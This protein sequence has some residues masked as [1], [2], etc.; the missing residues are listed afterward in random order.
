MA[1]GIGIPAYNEE[2][3]I[4]VVITHLKK[5]SDTIIVC[6]DGSND[7]TGEIAEKLGATVINHS[8]NMGYGGA[9]RSLFL[10]AKELKLD[11]L[12]TFDADGQHQI[13]DIQQVMKP[14]KDK[15]A[16]IVIGSRFLDKKSKEMP[17]YR[18]MGI[19]LIT[20][21]TNLSITE[22]LT[23]SQSGFRAY[24][25]EVLEKIVPTD[26]GMGVSTE[27]LIKASKLDFKIAEVPIEVLYTGD[28]ST[29]DP[30]SHGTS[31]IISTLK[32]MSIHNP[33]KFYGIPGL[34][35]LI[36]GLSF[37]A[38]T[39]QIYSVEQEIITNISL[40]GIGCVVLGSVFLMTAVILFSIVT[41][42][43]ER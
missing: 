26:E 13:D 38:W 29:H 21:V 37:I 42:V 22:K 23:D 16:D 31:V 32:F 17:N 8:K 40:I 35:F 5:I 24:S 2:K 33:L 25:K 4:A 10:K 39:I 27:I 19:K 3:N 14:I 34:I 7:L 15:I 43:K 6:N 41:V 28:T 30:V 18:K 9:I 1:I 11:T 12:I 36:I 20:K